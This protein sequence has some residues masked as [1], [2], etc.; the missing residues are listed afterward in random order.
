MPDNNSKEGIHDENGSIG[1][2]AGAGAGASTTAADI[3]NAE[4][5]ANRNM[6]PP[7]PLDTKDD[8]VFDNPS[9]K[10]VPHSLLM[11]PNPGFP[12]TDSHNSCATGG[13]INLTTYIKDAFLDMIEARAS[14]MYLHTLALAMKELAGMDMSATYMYLYL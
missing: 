12:P 3:S 4:D 1:S 2:A 14:Q 7:P 9:S 6:P 13:C 8:V 5:K 10:L 11:G